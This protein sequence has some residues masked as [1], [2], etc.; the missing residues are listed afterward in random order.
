MQM[1]HSQQAGTSLMHFDTA[2]LLLIS[3]FYCSFSRVNPPNPHSSTKLASMLLRAVYL[4]QQRTKQLANLLPPSILFPLSAQTQFKTSVTENDTN[5]SSD[6]VNGDILNGAVYTKGSLNGA[7]NGAKNGVINRANG[8]NLETCATLR[9]VIADALKRKQRPLESLQLSKMFATSAPLFTPSTSPS[10][11]AAPLSS[12]SSLPG[13]GTSSTPS[14]ATSPLEA[15]LQLAK[16]RAAG[17][18]NI[19]AAISTLSLKADEGDAESLFS[20]GLLHLFSLTP[21][22]QLAPLPRTTG[23]NDSAAFPPLFGPGPSPVSA[24]DNGASAVEFLSRAARLQHAEALLLMAQAYRNGG[25]PCGLRVPASLTA[26]RLYL[27]RSVAQGLPE[28]MYELGALH[29]SGHGVPR[30]P[31]LAFP[32]FLQ[33]AQ[34]QVPQ[35]QHNVAAMLYKGE[36]VAQDLPAAANWFAKAYENGVEESETFLRELEQQGYSTHVSPALAKKQ[37]E[38]LAR[39]RIEQEE[40]DAF[41]ASQRKRKAERKQREEEEARQ[42]SN[43]ITQLRAQVQ[44]ERADFQVA[45][46]A[47]RDADMA[48]HRAWLLSQEQAKAREQQQKEEAA[49]RKQQLQKEDAEYERRLQ[50]L[51]QA[52]RT[53]QQ[54]IEQEQ[55]AREDR[56]RKARVEEEYKKVA[57]LR[58]QVQQE[59]LDFQAALQA[60][61]DADVARHQAWVFSQLQAKA[62]RKQQSHTEQAVYIHKR[63]LQE[64]ETT[65]AGS[66]QLQQRGKLEMEPTQTVQD[67]P[68]VGIK[69]KEKQAGKEMTQD[70]QPTVVASKQQTQRQ[71]A[72][73]EEARQENQRQAEEARQEHVRQEASAKAKAEAAAKAEA[74]QK[75]QQEAA[76]AKREAERAAR[77]EAEAAKAKAEAA[78]KAEAEKKAQQEAAAAKREAERAAREEAEA[79]KAADRKAQEEAAAAK[80][81]ADRVAREEAAAKREA[82]KKE[83]EEKARLEMVRQAAARMEIQRKEEQDRMRILREE[84]E[85]VEAQRREE[86][87]KMA[88]LKQEAELMAWLRKEEERKMEMLRREAESMELQRQE[89]EKR[90]QEEKRMEELRLEVEKAIVMRQV[91]ERRKQQEQRLAIQQLGESERKAR[92]QKEKEEKMEMQ[93]RKQQEEEEARRAL[94]RVESQNAAQHVQLEKERLLT[95]IAALKAEKQRLAEMRARLVDAEKG[96]ADDATTTAAAAAA[97]ATSEQV[98][99]ATAKAT[100]EE[101]PVVPTATAKAAPEQQVAAVTAETAQKE[102]QVAPVTAEATRK[103]EQVAPVNAETSRKEEVAPATEKAAPKEEEVAPAVA[104][105]ASEEQAAGEVRWEVGQ[106]VKGPFGQGVLDKLYADGT[107]RVRMRPGPVKTS[108]ATHVPIAQLTLVAPPTQLTL[109][110]PTPEQTGKEQPSATVALE[111]PSATVAFKVG[112][113][114]SGSFGQGHIDFVYADGTFRIRLRPGPVKT[115]C[116]TR[117]TA[118]DLTPATA[119]D[120]A[121]SPIENDKQDS[122]LDASSGAKSEVQPIVNK[123]EKQNGEALLPVGT[124]VRGSFGQG[125]VD[126]VYSDGTYRIRLRPGPVK[127]SCVTRVPRNK[128]I[129]LVALQVARK[130]ANPLSI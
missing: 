74:E 84:A 9:H 32:L 68:V 44:Q 123:K 92:Q 115:S 96:A 104:A 97:T 49:V 46:Q 2:T 91:E 89:A 118:T 106:T 109:A 76:A 25:L 117:I 59:R 34:H 39:M 94:E 83:Q 63:Q 75:A 114:V 81:E 4:R 119:A 52:D 51:Q 15:V 17:E 67:L 125:S 101:A 126:Y 98:A 124:Q 7:L 77:E 71:K 35:A 105:S 20:L 21:H 122:G 86:E 33:A 128:L 47:E 113:C 100:R 62:T 16:K 116:V 110:P 45:L 70:Q 36:G 121:A 29:Y 87:K 107:W 61:R 103:E 38:G 8:S 1:N 28:A 111:Q 13:L 26:A 3:F 19:K 60:E 73:E 66:L 130:F 11:A 5:S 93:R 85:R 58:A 22:E 40:L 78:A 27:E 82:E 48:R 37:Q 23:L 90:K 99:T 88:L 64:E 120:S 112:D 14:V 24:N 12:L 57:Q 69:E 54:R 79:K 72:E 65:A 102:E 55:L 18:V 129:R 50:T 95:K 42:R 53:R 10:F 30:A 43:K 31:Q 56:I 80:R 108:C 41:L 6:A 127:T